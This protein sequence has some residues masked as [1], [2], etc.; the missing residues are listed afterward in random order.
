M[1]HEERSEFARAGGTAGG[2]ARAASLSKKRRSEIAKTAS[3]ARWA[4][5]TAAEK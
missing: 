2:K 1:T 3:A 5:K 4:K